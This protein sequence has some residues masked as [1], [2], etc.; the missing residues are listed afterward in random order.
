METANIAERVEEQLREFSRASSKAIIRTRQELE[1][2]VENNPLARR[3][4]GDHDKLHVTFLFDT[5]DETVASKLDFT[6]DPGEM[7]AI[8]G[9]E[10]YLYCPNGYARTK[11]KRRL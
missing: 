1:K 5:P 9:K 7:F 4:N 10:V 2:I 8:V 3:A 11:L 6:P